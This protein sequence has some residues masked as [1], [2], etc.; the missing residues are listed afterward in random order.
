MGATAEEQLEGQGNLRHVPGASYFELAKEPSMSKDCGQVVLE[1]F[2]RLG[3]G[4]A[5]TST[6]TVQKPKVELFVGNV[7]G[8]TSSSWCPDCSRA[9]PIVLDECL[10]AGW[11]VVAVG[12]GERDDWKLDARGADNPFRAKDG[13]A[14]TGVPTARLVSAEGAELA[15]LGPELEE[16]DVEKIRGAVAA[17]LAAKSG[18]LAE[19]RVR[20]LRAADYLALPSKVEAARLEVFT[21]NVDGSTTSS[22]CPD[23]R[24]AVPV[25][26]EAAL[27]TKWPIVA[28][29][30]GE[31]DDWKLDARG[32]SNPFRA[33][34]GLRLTGVPTVRLAGPEGELARLGPELEEEDVEKVRSA[35]EG[36]VK[37]HAGA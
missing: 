5:G 27:G 9:V 23:C 19:A 29:G 37:V 15:R 12:V 31:R 33:E 13:L 18:A 4:S 1:C 7:D 8:S 6:S 35:I 20:H 26:L 32:A 30:V 36:L 34:D 24:R 3:K 28:I 11:P 22:W 10:K 17:V 25:V 2:A 21:G 16:E 14:L